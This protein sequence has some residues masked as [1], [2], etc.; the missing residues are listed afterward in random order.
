MFVEYI[1]TEL[2]VKKHWREVFNLMS[3][4]TQMMPPV[5]L[6][7][8]RRPKESYTEDLLQY[9]IENYQ[10]TTNAAFNLAIDG[11][12]ETAQ[13]LEYEE[14]ITESLQKFLEEFKI[15]TSV[16][17]VDLETYIRE[18]IGRYRQTD[19][20]ALV[21]VFPKYWGEPMKTEYVPV[22]P[23]FGAEPNRRVD[24]DVCLVP[25]ENITYID[26]EKV[27]YYGGE[28]TL[29][30][31]KEEKTY[32]YYWGISKDYTFLIYPFFDDKKKLNYAE[33]SYYYN[34]LT[35]A[36]AVVIANKKVIKQENKKVYSFVV[37]DYI[38]AAMWGNLAI[39][40]MSDLQ[41][42]ETRFTFLEKWMLVRDCNNPS[43][44]M[45]PDGVH[46]GKHC[47]SNIE[48]NQVTLCPTC[49]GVGSIADTSPFGTHFIK[50]KTG[51]D[52]V[53]ATFTPPVGFISPDPSILKHSAERTEY[54]SSEMDNELCIVRQNM[55]NQSGTSK[56]YDLQNKIT[57][58]TNIVS[59]IYRVYEQ[60]VRIIE[61][62]IDRKETYT[63]T[64]PN[65]FDIKNANDLAAEI[66][67]DKTSNLPNPLIAEKMERY[68]IK[69][70]GDSPEMDKTINFISKYDILFAYG[71]NEL[72][73]AKAVLGESV[74]TPQAIVIHNQSF[75]IVKEIAEENPNTFLTMKDS[76]IK[77]LFDAKI[78]EI[79]PTINTPTGIDGTAA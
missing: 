55:T 76:E 2:P 15:N 54:Y 37:A 11:Y 73:T 33:V 46:A 51:F 43:A 66:A 65:D 24:I 28:W 52:Q 61:G 68:Y 49:M 23:N 17:Q 40:Q 20:N 12:I 48:T 78:L 35:T 27:V 74:I 60:V 30:P 18:T 1:N 70:Y 14:T 57:K 3:V 79:M 8:K 5:D 77:A 7:T 16:E 42:C 64:L 38:G 22:M 19:P 69:L 21:V 72:M 58:V 62:F 67:L 39:N 10:S 59:D 6:F 29:K 36:P 13:N 34:A 4:H 47:V 44:F 50:E 32:P 63:L 71:S 45:Q 9:R 25:S 41:V 31:Y 26:A 56:S 53:N 75:Q